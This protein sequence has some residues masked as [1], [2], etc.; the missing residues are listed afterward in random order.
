MTETNEPATDWTATGSRLEANMTEPG[1]A[2]P[3]LGSNVTDSEVPVDGYL[4]FLMQ[5]VN[6]RG[7]PFRVT[8]SVG[9]AMIS[10]VLTSEREY[11]EGLTQALKIV[12][13]RSGLRE[14]YE[15][16]ANV[17]RERSEEEGVSE[18]NIPTAE[19]LA[20]R[21]TEAI[22]ERLVGGYERVEGETPH[23]IH[24]RD[25]TIMTP[26][27]ESAEHGGLWRGRLEAVDGF[28]F[29]SPGSRGTSGGSATG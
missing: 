17:A 25:V 11:F 22:L 8:L 2:S 5:Q 19:E 9:G 24:L 13:G 15:R 27:F 21:T 28:M 23:Y 4:R 26:G 3:A 1:A 18:E 12:I 14:Q 29:G 6:Q 10:G 7:L 20:A 16:G